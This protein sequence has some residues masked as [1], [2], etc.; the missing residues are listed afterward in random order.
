MRLLFVLFLGL[1]SGLSAQTLL[2]A[3]GSNWKFYDQGDLGTAS[4]T[5]P[6]FND[7]LWSSGNAQLG[8]GEG[9]ESTVVGYGS[10]ANN[11]YITTYFRQ[12]V[13]VT[14]P[15]QFSHL[16]LNLLR[17]DGAVVYINGV[18]VW[19]SNMPGG[20][21]GFNTLA[22][23]TVAWPYENDWHTTNV[24]AAHLVNGNNTISVEV[25]Q[26]NGGSSDVSFD[27]SMIAHSGLTASV[28][29]G[30]YLQKVNQNEVILRW[31]TDVPTDSKVVYGISP[32]QLLSETVL[33]NFT[34]DHEVK[35]TG[36]NPSSTYY[37]SVGSFGQPIMQGGN[38]YF[39]TMPPAGESGDYRFLVLGDCGTGQQAQLDVKNAVV[40]TYGSHY[41][42]V[43]ILGDNAYQSGFDSEY[44]SN[45]FENKYNEIFENT[46]IW[47]TP[48]NH[49]YNNHIPFSPDPAY[50]DI[51][52]LPTNGECGGVPSGTEKY[53]SFNYGNIHFVS[54]DS[55]D[56]SRS[57][58]GPMATWLA[59]D[60]ANN[61][62][63]WTVAFWHHPPY[64]KGSHDSDNDNFLDGELVEIRE[65]ILP[66]IEAYGV[67]LVLNGHSHTYERSQL[68]DGHYGY[69]YDFGTSYTKD[70][71]SG[72]YPASCPYYKRNASGDVHQGT[73]YAVMGNSGKIS[74]IDSEWPHPVMYSYS[75]SEVG[76][77][78]L[79]VNENRLDATFHTGS[80]YVFDHFTIVKSPS[81]RNTVE[82]CINEQITLEPSWPVDGMSVWNPGSSM[83][84]NYTIQ[85]LSSGT[86]VRTD[87]HGCLP[88][89]FDLIVLQNDT[90]GYLS[91][92]VVS[93]EF[94][95]K[96][97]WVNHTLHIDQGNFKFQFFELYD[98]MGRQVARIEVN[99][100]VFT[101]SYSMLQSGLYYIKPENSYSTKSI[102]K[103]E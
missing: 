101:Q 31:R 102:F 103:H 4:W 22:D 11:K 93:G 78:V 52:N 80:D 37:Y 9:D 15:Q 72:D 34:T 74:G 58:N 67:D 54:L 24:S 61:T 13:F 70:P 12:S 64:T 47:P 56:E 90:C 43:L 1:T 26:E 86:I 27:F 32:V 39:E 30:P 33:T 28:I 97:Y 96:A 29:R 63:E 75:A 17:D 41:Q 36:L 42:G 92:P 23:G 81:Q 91:T 3:Q 46:V 50:Y 84:V 16:E 66:L 94:D 55:Y 77:I 48:G 14:N 10:D 68:I 73:V 21:I 98:L 99:S 95:Y 59:N 5:D 7:A 89:T 79:E 38:L 19:R 57:V 20:T 71:T 8:Y 2:V 82:V 88:D 83:A 65:E 76:A 60:L 49:D 40:N 45:F 25:H 44:Q 85:P 35:L 62:Q 6:S 51:F 18:E 53:Y 87:T 69:S 100:P